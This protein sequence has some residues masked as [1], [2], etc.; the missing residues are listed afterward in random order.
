MQINEYFSS[1]ED[2][3]IDRGKLHSLET[4]FG[5][6]IIAVICGIKSWEKIALFGRLRQKELSAIINFTNGVPSHDT[7]ER[8]Y[9]LKTG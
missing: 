7:M 5:L 3:R 1:I 8:V 2:P 6:T 9:I 4:I